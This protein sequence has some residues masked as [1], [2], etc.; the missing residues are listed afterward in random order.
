[1]EGQ[2]TQDKTD[3]STLRREL[4]TATNRIT[5][6]ERSGGSTNDELQSLRKKNGDLSAQLQQAVDGAVIMRKQGVE[7]TETNAAQARK[8]LELQGEIDALKRRLAELE[9]VQKQQDDTFKIRVADLRNVNETLQRFARDK[10]FQDDLKGP[11]VKIALDCWGGDA[12]NYTEAQMESA[13]FDEAVNRVYPR[14]KSFETTTDLAGIRVRVNTTL[15]HPITN[16]ISHLLIFLT[17]LLPSFLLF[18]SSLFNYLYSSQF[19]VDH[20]LAGKTELSEDAILMAFGPDFVSRLAQA[21][22]SGTLL[23]SP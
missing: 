13:R 8:I 9:A 12:H 6:L 14:M 4:T 15:F 16:F 18:C 7:Q 21:R 5:D 3:L 11:M 23:S 10:T 20:I 1:M 17:F 19:P 22:K 2:A